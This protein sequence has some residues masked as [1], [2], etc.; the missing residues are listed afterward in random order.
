M[1]INVRRFVLN[2]RAYLTPFLLLLVFHHLPILIAYGAI[3][4]PVDFKNCK[5]VKDLFVWFDVAFIAHLTAVALITLSTCV[6]LCSSVYRIRKPETVLIL[7]LFVHYVG[8]SVWS[9]YGESAFPTDTSGC[10]NDSETIQDAADHITGV[11]HFD[12]IVSVVIVCAASC[13][14]Y[15][16]GVH[17]SDD[18]VE[19]EKRWQVRCMRMFRLFTCK[20]SRSH[21]TDEDIFESLGKILGKF[22]V[23]R[24]KTAKYQGLQFNDLMFCLG[25]VSDAQ[26]EEREENEEEEQQTM[27]QFPQRQEEAKLKDLA[28]YGRLAVGM[29]GWPMFVWYTPLRWFKVLDCWSGCKRPRTSEQQVIDHDNAVTSNRASFLNYTGIDNDA[30][31]YLNCYNFVFSS[32]YSIVKDQHRRQLIISVRGSFSF[33]DF[34]TDGLAHIVNMDASELPADIPNANATATH[35][36]MLR[37][38]RSLFKDL[39]E[40]S[41]KS[42]FW[43][44]AVANCNT[45][46]DNPWTIVVCGHSMGAA[47]GAIL[48]VLLKTVFPNTRA[49]LYAPPMLFD[50]ATAEWTKSFM[51]TAV[52]G[53]DIVPRLSIANVTRLRDEMIT[54]FNAVAAERLIK[55]KY[56]RKK[57]GS[58]IGSSKRMQRV[59]ELD[60]DVTGR[61]EPVSSGDESPPVST[62]TR[63]SRAQTTHTGLLGMDFLHTADADNVQEVDVPGEI[64][65]ILTAKKARTCSCTMILGE[66]E[67]TY[68]LR[69]AAY[70]RRI[71]TT[72]RAIQDHMV[73]HYDRNIRHLVA[74]CLGYSLLEEREQLVIDVEPDENVS[75]PGPVVHSREDP[76]DGRPW[77]TENEHSF[78]KIG[79]FTATP[80]HA[81]KTDLIGEEGVQGDHPYQ[82]VEDVA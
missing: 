17:T 56:A 64:V 77:I 63:D 20:S 21:A 6:T 12:F 69:D 39:Q 47:V 27:R 71:W 55:V 48:C 9:L 62:E 43:D 79:D 22:F 40:G 24:Y 10:A 13:S 14:S 37:T 75:P 54:H 53:D 5:R 33:Y 68:T 58:S 59:A 26:R 81:N 29:Y 70:F 23:V 45:K 52:Y 51:T 80:R 76:K 35:Y 73:H 7:L 82:R 4:R 3:A 42:L 32:P 31:V 38:A 36:G 46:R 16:C 2:P 25:L 44:F 8:N 1:A 15:L 66:Q 60:V 74:N 30:L 67:L 34:V 50:P 78:D 28:Y 49:Y 72:S 57:S 41:R 18:I 11:Q 61:T 65:H 19:A